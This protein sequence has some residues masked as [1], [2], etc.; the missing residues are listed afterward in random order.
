[1][2]K[3]ENLSQDESENLNENVTIRRKRRKRKLNLPAEIKENPKLRKY[4]Q[5]RFSLFHK[6]DEGVK[7]DEGTTTNTQTFI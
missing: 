7:L 1:M 4:W 6:F 3:F 5:R 2:S